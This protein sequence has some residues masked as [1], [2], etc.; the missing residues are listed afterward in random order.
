MKSIELAHKLY[1]DED[2]NKVYEYNGKQYKA[3]S[4]IKVGELAVNVAV[5]VQKFNA[6]IEKA[7]ESK[8]EGQ[9]LPL[10]DEEQCVKDL[11]ER[12]KQPENVA[13]YNVSTEIND[14]IAKQEKAYAGLK[15][16]YKND[17]E[18]LGSRNYL[19]RS[20][21][22]LLKTEE[23]EEAKTFNKEL[24]ESYI[25]NPEEFTYVRMQKQMNFDPN[26]E[27]A[28]GED[29]I[30][31]LEF[32]RDH[33]AISHEFNEFA[34][35]A[36][37]KT[38]NKG[39]A[40]SQAVNGFKGL[41]QKM[42]YPFGQVGGK[43]NDPQE[44]L[45]LPKLSKDQAEAIVKNYGKVHKREIVDD[46]G[47]KILTNAN[48]T[49]S[50]Q[51]IINDE[52]LDKKS[53]IP[54]PAEFFK[55][56]EDMGLKIEKNFFLK[57]KAVHT[58]PNTHEEKEVS[59]YEL[60]DGKA[61]V[62]VKERTQAE[63]NAIRGMSEAYNLKFAMEFHNRMSKQLNKPYLIG[64][65]MDETK[66][67]FF[68]RFFRRT[69]TEYKE[70]INALK[71]YTDT[72]NPTSDRYLNRQLLEKKAR[73]YLEY[74]GNDE[75]NN[76]NPTRIARINLAK[77][78]IKALYEMD[79]NT[80]LIYSKINS[81]ITSL[82]PKALEADKAQDHKV[83]DLE[84]L[85]NAQVKAKGVHKVIDLDISKDEEEIEEEVNEINNEQNEQKVE[86]VKAEP[87]K[88]EAKKE[89]IKVVVKESKEQPKKV[90]QDESTPTVAPNGSWQIQ[91]ISSPNKSAMEKAWK[92]LKQK[93]TAL[94]N[95]PHEVES[96]D[97][98]KKGTFYRLKAGAFQNRE[99]AD[100]LCNSIKAAGGSCIVKKK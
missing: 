87:V 63:I 10:L 90:D 56:F 57:Y 21:I 78:V 29:K 48:L 61:N 94:K 82:V 85:E 73:E 71:D 97:L 28:L 4:K 12:C 52:Y 69:S 9:K 62:T 72:T 6:V 86:E 98:G 35:P 1:T 27:I 42:A 54:S 46:K 22:F 91:L 19:S 36:N 18:A 76:T 2:S 64:Q 30:K 40:Y 11:I 55:K 59:M 99:D 16:Q 23:T 66:G 95:L 96:A 31:M 53:N 14:T 43:Y 88:V 13:L 65:A 39:Y 50:E 15:E 41:V 84:E 74:T 58:D 92:D 24:I 34:D 83:I 93:Y 80:N 70:F 79:K 49:T 32:Y 8:P 67:G 26:T 100:K 47:N 51:R 3:L 5:Y 17:F 89:E 75:I 25:K 7:N 81:E 38:F 33:I 77:A 60:Y 45:C 20:I 44:F 37:V 68:E